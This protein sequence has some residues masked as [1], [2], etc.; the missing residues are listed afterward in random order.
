[1]FDFVTR[2]KKVFF[3]LGRTM[4]LLTG[5]FRP[6]WTSQ[7]HE[8]HVPGVGWGPR[9]CTVTPRGRA[10][11]QLRTEHPEACLAWLQNMG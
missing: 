1:M 3:C 8:A 10:L 6:E 5:L 9:S 11:S 7:A 2:G 4:A